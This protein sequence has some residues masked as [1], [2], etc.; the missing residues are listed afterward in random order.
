MAL[1][2]WSTQRQ[3]LVANEWQPSP[4]EGMNLAWFESL[5]LV[6]LVQRY[7]QLNR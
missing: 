7:G 4:M 6:N 1:M 3:R 5:G 2:D